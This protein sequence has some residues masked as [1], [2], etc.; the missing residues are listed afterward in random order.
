[1]LQQDTK[2]CTKCGVDQPLTNYHKK[3]SGL[4]SECKSCKAAYSK[5]YHQRPEVRMAATKAAKRYRYGLT[6]DEVEALETVKRCAI[7]HG[8]G[9]VIDHCHDTGRLRGV[10]CHPCNQSL[11]KMHD[12]PALL[13]RA[14]KYLEETGEPHRYGV[15]SKFDQFKKL[16]TG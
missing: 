2:V 11:G 5:E 1:M 8:P 16:S 10:L 12:S 9:E 7:C 14:A 4:R 13:R 6:T 3:G 15:W